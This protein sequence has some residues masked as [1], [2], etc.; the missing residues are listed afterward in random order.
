MLVAL[1]AA[2]DPCDYLAAG[3]P[4]DVYVS[5]ALEVLGTLYGDADMAGVLG[6]LPPGAPVHAA[7]LFAT[8]ALDWWA[9][10]RGAGG[11]SQR[12]ASTL[13]V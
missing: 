11:V 6:A 2:C 3:A 1:L 4:T 8:V 5:V 10:S 7:A 12:G 9:T 13:S